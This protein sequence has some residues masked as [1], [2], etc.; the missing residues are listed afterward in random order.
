MESIGAARLDQSS[1]CLA[2][3]GRMIQITPQIRILVAVEAIDGRK[4]ID[5]IAQLCREKLNA[6]PFS[7]YLFI[8]RT[9][10]GTAI[11]V[12]Q[13]D[14]QGFWLATKRLSKGLSRWWPTGT[15]AVRTLRAH[16]AQ[17]AAGGRQS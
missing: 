4:G 9:R 17:T 12:L 8:F 14:G 7:G 3:N 1:A 2:R 15:E 16:Q 6:D 5:A 13:F 10:R 11:R